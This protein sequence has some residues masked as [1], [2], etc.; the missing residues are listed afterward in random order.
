M[1]RYTDW[2][3]VFGG[4]LSLGGLFAWIAFVSKLIPG[5]RIEELQAAVDRLLIAPATT[6]VLA[7]AFLFGLAILSFLGTIEVNSFAGAADRR[8]YFGSVENDDTFLRLP[9]DGRKRSL[10]WTT[11]GSSTPV[12]VKVEGHPDIR[13]RVRSWRV[14]EL[15]VP[16]SFR[17]PV[18]L[19][20]PATPLID[21]GRENPLEL[22]IRLGEEEIVTD[23]TG[24]L[25][26]VGCDADVDIP[27]RLRDRWESVLEA[28]KQDRFVPYWTR[29]HD[30]G[31]EVRELVPNE[32]V[33]V[34]LFSKETGKLLGTT[35]AIT[36]ARIDDAADFPQVVDLK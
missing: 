16:S 7:G 12:R 9:A 1:L 29:P 25:V 8:L 31:V 4:L 6:Y 21:I 32:T 2:F 36:I 19:V 28:R 22:R 30:L 35:G 18:L 20:R 15:H 17:R 11:P 27:A 34:E 26:F 10:H 33:T 5:R 14:T 13:V 3:G 24:H 23:F